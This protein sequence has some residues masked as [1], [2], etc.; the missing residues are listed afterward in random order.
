ME[1]TIGGIKCESILLDTGAGQ[2]VLRSDMVPLQSHTGKI[3]ITKS[4]NGITQSHQIT[5]VVD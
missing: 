5:K 1:G 3:K 4:Y 2:N